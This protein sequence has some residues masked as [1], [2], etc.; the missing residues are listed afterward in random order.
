MCTLVILRRPNHDWPLIIGA[1]RDEKRDRPWASPARHWPDRTHV[2]AG[3]DELA[4]GTWLGVNDDGLVAAVLNRS[5][6]LGPDPDRRSR[7]ELPLEALDHAEA[8]VAAEALAE[9]DPDAYRPFNL[10]VGDARNAYWICSVREDGTPG[11]RVNEIPQ[12]VSMLTDLDRND[13]AAPRVRLYL[14][15][16]ETAPPP[17]PDTDT[18][19]RDENRGW[20]Q[21]L[22]ADKEFEN[23]VGPKGAMNIDMSLQT[24]GDFGTVSSALIAVPALVT[25]TRRTRWLFAAGAPDTCPFEPVE[26]S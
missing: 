10:F 5:G 15:R 19:S 20:W 8:I 21:A 25:P 3:R 12:G 9:L 2:V 22:L 13:P 26:L 17:N 1:N 7:G 16:F 14:S 18:W 24:P 6:S 11:M 4:G 23:G